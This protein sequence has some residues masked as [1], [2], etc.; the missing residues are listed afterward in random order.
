MSPMKL[1]VETKPGRANS[2][3]TPEPYVCDRRERRLHVGNASGLLRAAVVSLRAS[4]C[5]LLPCSFDCVLKDIKQSFPV[6]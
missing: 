2:C 6:G 1:P 3:T 4:D 5:L